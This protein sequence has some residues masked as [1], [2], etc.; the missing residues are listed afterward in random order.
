MRNQ[1]TI[2]LNKVTSCNNRKKYVYFHYYGNYIFVNANR[3]KKY[4]VKH[5]TYY[6]CEKDKDCNPG[7]FNKNVSEFGM[8]FIDQSVHFSTKYV[9]TMLHP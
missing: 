4:I 6:H 7:I 1:T 3:F 9:K 2:T 8:S 5:F